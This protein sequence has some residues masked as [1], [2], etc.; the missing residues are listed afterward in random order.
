[1]ILM[2]TY[3]VMVYYIVLLTHINDVYKTLKTTFTMDLLYKHE[4]VT[5]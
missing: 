5:V 4:G 1:M 2:N 3:F